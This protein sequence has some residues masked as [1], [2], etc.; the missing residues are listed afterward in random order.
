MVKQSVYEDDRRR[1]RL[2]EGKA[3]GGANEIGGISPDS[4]FFLPPA[5]SLLV[6]DT[7]LESYPGPTSAGRNWFWN[8]RKVLESA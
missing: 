1:P 7:S 5:F 3:K 8:T 4:L 2:H 6:L